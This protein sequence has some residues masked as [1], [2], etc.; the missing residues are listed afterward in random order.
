[1]AELL[2]LTEAGLYCERG[3]FHLD[4]WAPVE[5]ALVTHAHADHAAA[6]VK[7]LLCAQPSA[8]LLRHRLPESTVESLPYRE[9]RQLGEVRVSF[10]PSGH[11]LGAAQIRLQCEGEVWVV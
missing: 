9:P 7:Q 5:R 10:H 1:M 11:V 8:S 3:G 4:P 2:T 6:G